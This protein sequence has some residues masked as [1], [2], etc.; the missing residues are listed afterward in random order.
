MTSGA[1]V[2]A[3]VHYWR[4][5]R[6][7]YDWLTPDLPICRDVLPPE[8][9]PLFAAAGVDGIVLVQAAAT[10]A[11]TRFLLSLAET[12]RRVL[13]VVGWTD[14]LEADAP[15]RLAELACDKRLRG[16]RPMWQDIAEDDWLLRPE[17]DAAYRAVAE[18]GLTFDALAQVRHLPHLPRLVERHPGLPMVIDHAAKPQIAPGR[19]DVWRTRMAAIAAFP[20]VHCK[21]SGLVTEAPPGTPYE[22]FIPC[23]ETLLELFGPRR[24]IFGSDWPVL[25]LRQDYATWWDWSHRLMAQLAPDEQ[26]AVFGGNAMSFYRLEARA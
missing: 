2:D 4:V 20:H 14:M 15:D 26:A 1:V 7:D 21:L 10:A 24:L 11:E 23:A 16:V 19:L 13:G 17:Q 9:A 18:L 8:A 6:G 22:A 5:G 3:H 12:D 25:T